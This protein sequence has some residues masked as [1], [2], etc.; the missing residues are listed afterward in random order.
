MAPFA[1][2]TAA[3]RCRWPP[4]TTWP[5]S[6]TGSS[7][8][9]AA[10]LRG[11]LRRHRAA[12]RPRLPPALVPL[13]EQQP[14]RRPLGRLGRGAR[15][16]ARG[17]RA[18]GARRRRARRSRCGHASARSRPTANPGQTIDD[19]LVAMG[20]GIDA[21]LDA[22][23]VTAYGEPMVA[24]GITDG[25]TPHEPGALL[26]VRRTGPARAR[27]AG[28]RD[29]PA[30]ARG[31]RAGA[32][33]RRRRRH[34][35]GSAAHRRPRPARPS[36]A[37]G[38]RHRIRPCAYQYRC[39]GAIFLNE[40]VQCAVNP[41]AGHE[42]EAVTPAAE[43]AATGRRGGRW[44]GGPRVRAPTRRARPPRRA[45]RGQRPPRRTA[46]PGRGAPIPT[47]PGCSPGSSARPRTPASCS[48]LGTAGH[49][50]AGRRR[51]RV[52]RRARRG[53]ATATSAS[54]TSRLARRR[55]RPSPDPVVVEGAARRPCRSR[56]TGPA[57]RARRRS[58]FPTSRCWR[59]SSGCPGRFRLVAAAE[60]AGVGDRR[61][62]RRRPPPT[63]A[64]PG[65]T[66][67][68]RRRSPRCT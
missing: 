61:P 36:C 32:G 29:G 43:R 28:H 68:T 42:A 18:G 44:P 13:A 4:T 33:R 37:A 40:P 3:Y 7:T 38:Q 59:P 11:R 46:G 19:A 9:P 8:P 16:A 6:S 10:C 25:H 49:G 26:P 1:S 62:R 52:G 23:H 5:G 22:I 55:A 47:S 64:S 50:A 21:G 66:R 58:S 35:D 51:A 63:C 24:T 48:D 30:H 53:P 15:R 27:R 57:R 45:A 60:R 67:P 20:L 65:A 41:D 56:C 31:G 12:R 17:G 54:T 14:A 39:I 34:R 2:P